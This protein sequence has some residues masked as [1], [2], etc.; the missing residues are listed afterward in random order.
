MGP[1]KSPTP[2]NAWARLGENA[3]RGIVD[4]LYGPDRLQGREGGAGHASK[5]CAASGMFASV[6]ASKV[7]W[8]S[9]PGS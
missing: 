4:S 9:V 3:T 2:V 1:L 8:N 6:P 5:V 7:T